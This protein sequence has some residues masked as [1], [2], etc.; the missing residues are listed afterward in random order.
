MIT[1]FSNFSPNWG[2]IGGFSLMVQGIGRSPALAKNLFI[3]FPTTK[4]NPPISRLFH[5]IFIPLQQ[6][7]KYQIPCF[8]QIKSAFLSF[9]LLSLLLYHFYFALNFLDSKF[10]LNLILINVPC[11][12]NVAF[13]FEKDQKS[14]KHLSSDSRNPIINFFNSNICN[15][16]HMGKFPPT[17]EH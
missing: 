15:C 17:H 12:Q 6:F 14:Q 16:P 7:T 11:L 2:N 13:S 3:F 5:Q 4:K 1:R 10:M 8:N 9:Q